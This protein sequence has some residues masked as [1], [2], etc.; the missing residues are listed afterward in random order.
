M[1]ITLFMGSNGY[2]SCVRAKLIVSNARYEDIGDNNCRCPNNHR[3]TAHNRQ[4]NMMRATV[5][6]LLFGDILN[7]AFF[8][9]HSFYNVIND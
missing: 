4:D 8:N 5:I 6:P 3:E 9:C 1:R 2:P 7:V